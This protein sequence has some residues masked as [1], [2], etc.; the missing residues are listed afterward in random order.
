[1]RKKLLAGEPVPNRVDEEGKLTT[2]TQRKGFSVQEIKAPSKSKGLVLGSAARW[3]V[4]GA[5]LVIL[6]LRLA[7]ASLAVLAPF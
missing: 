1:M 7:G 6:A 2:D 3:T 5:I 4:L